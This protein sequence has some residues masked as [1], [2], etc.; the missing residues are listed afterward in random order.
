MQLDNDP[1]STDVH[2]GLSAAEV[3][4]SREAYG[5]NAFTPLPVKP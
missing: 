3:A 4:A 5:A 1:V 2:T